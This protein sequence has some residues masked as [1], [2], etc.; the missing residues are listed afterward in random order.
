M[1]T[2][3]MLNLVPAI[4]T[5]VLV[6]IVESG[7]APAYSCRSTAVLNL[8]LNLVDPLLYSEYS[9]RI[10]LEYDRSKYLVLEYGVTACVTNYSC[11]IV[12]ER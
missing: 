11:T 1:A 12:P 4:I 7:A 6:Y 2:L 10:L 8:V 9:C 3:A 5:A